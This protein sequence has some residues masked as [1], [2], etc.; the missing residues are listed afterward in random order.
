MDDILWDIFL[1]TKYG[2]RV[3]VISLIRSL[4]IQFDA[5][6]S[7]QL[8][9]AFG[10]MEN[11]SKNELNIL[12]LLLKNYLEDLYELITSFH[13]LIKLNYINQVTFTLFNG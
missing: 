11:L 5:Y 10:S 9:R 13:S 3:Y 2:A 8:N 4:L 6:D 1:L 7:L 12:I